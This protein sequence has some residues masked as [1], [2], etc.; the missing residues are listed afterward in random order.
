MP[1]SV[2]SSPGVHATGVFSDLLRRKAE[3]AAAPMIVPSQGIHL[4]F[5]A[6]ILQGNSAIMV[7]HTSDGRV[8]FAIPWHGHTLVGTTDT[9]IPAATLESV[10]LEQEIEFILS[11]AGDYLTKASTRGDVLSVFA[12]V[13]RTTVFGIALREGGGGLGGQERDGSDRGGR[14]RPAHTHPFL[15]ARVASDTAAAVAD[16]MAGEL[17]WSQTAKEQ[18]VA[19][20][21]AFASHYILKS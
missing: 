20:F 2:Y 15:H 12:E 16:L 13:R 9:P 4:V 10:A 21:H 6:S 18:Q 17:G 8:L 3:P 11:T 14:S 5:D 7:P 1:S 19:A